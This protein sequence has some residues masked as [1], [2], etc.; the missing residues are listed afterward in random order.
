MMDIHIL[1]RYVDVSGLAVGAHAY[2]IP[3]SGV[4][5]V[6]RGFWSAGLL[7]TAARAWG[8]TSGDVGGTG[9]TGAR[10]SGAWRSGSRF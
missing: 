4:N 10:A 5:R 6:P 2:V 7:Y 8:F 3:T 9:V 1:A